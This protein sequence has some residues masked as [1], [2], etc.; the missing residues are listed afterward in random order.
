MACFIV[1][2]VGRS[3]QRETCEISEDLSAIARGYSTPSR[4]DYRLVPGDV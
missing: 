4:L 2:F 1:S 3:N